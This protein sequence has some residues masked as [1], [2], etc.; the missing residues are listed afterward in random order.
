[1]KFVQLHNHSFFS[2]L[3]GVASPEEIAKKAKEYGMSAVALTDHGTMSGLLRFS[4]ACVKEGIKPILGCEFYLNSNRDN[5]K[6]KEKG[7]NRHIVLLAKS[8]KGY[9]NL[10]KINYDSIVNGFYYKG[11]TDEKFIFSHSR[12]IICMTACLGSYLSY[13]ILKDRIDLAEKK[14]LKYKKVFGDDLYV[15]IMFN[16]LEDQKR[17]NIQLLKMSKRMNVKYIITGDCHYVNEGDEKIQDLMIAI[18]RKKSISDPNVFRFSTRNLFFH[19]PKDYLRFNKEYGYNL[20]KSVIMEG[21]YNTAEVAE[22]CDFHLEHSENPKFPR[23]IDDDKNEVNADFILDKKCRK[24]LLKLNKDTEYKDR[25]ELELKVIKEKNFSDYFLI[26][27]D[28]IRFCEKKG[29][30]HGVGRGSAAGSL[31]SYL[32][33]ITLVDPI[34]FD[35][36]F[37]R[38]LNKSRKDPPDIDIDFESDR[39]KEIEDY[40]K[41]KYGHD[42]VAHIITFTTFR[43]KGALWDVFRAYEKDKDPEFLSIIKKIIDNPGKSSDLFPLS[44]QL[45]N[46][47]D[48]KEIN[49]VKKNKKIFDLAKKLIGR[50]RNVG[51]HAG[52]TAITP[53]PL[54]KHIPVHKVKGDIVTAFIEGKDYRELSDLGVLKVDLLGLDQ[55]DIIKRSIELAK[56]TRNEDVDIYNFNLNDKELFKAIRNYDC[57]GIFQFENTSINDF[58][59]RTKPDCFEDMAT[60]NALYRPAVINA[61]EHEH[62]I[63]RKIKVK[64]WEKENNKKYEGKTE[65]GKLLRNTYGTIAFQEQFMNILHKIGLFTLEEADRA[66]KTFKILYLRRQKTDDKKEDPEL[67]AVV[68]KFREG[69][70]KTT[71]LSDKQIDKWVD[72]LAEFAEYAF[73]RSHSVSYAFIAM[74][75]LYMREYYPLCFYSAI[76]DRTKNGKES[77]FRKTNKMEKYFR[78]ITDSRKLRFA[79]IDINKSKLRFYPDEGKIRIPFSFVPGIGKSLAGEIYK[80]APYRSFSQFCM[81]ELKLRTNKTAILNLIKIGA[82]DSLNKDR[83]ALVLFYEKWSLIRAKYKKKSLKEIKKTMLE[84]WNGE[85]EYND[86]LPIRGQGDFTEEE[87]EEMEKEICKFNVFHRDEDLNSS[88]AEWLHKNH[89]IREITASDS[90]EYCF[91][92]EDKSQERKDR[93]KKPYVY[94]SIVDFKGNRGSCAVFGDVYRVVKN[95]LKKDV[96]YIAYCRKDKRKDV[97]TRELLTLGWGSNSY[98]TCKYNP[99]QKIDVYMKEKGFL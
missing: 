35:L 97:K 84:I 22:K 24:A 33:G 89:G 15:E 96:Y 95:R 40:L 50:I 28:L 2:I 94:L 27:E 36:I 25:M 82:F 55:I 75:T 66:R 1:M 62:Y 91:K 26:I 65:I 63:K 64:N 76:L 90:G 20:S 47:V 19:H 56:K 69:A 3:D 30:D 39:K 34:R 44:D 16:E 49:Y 7:T 45:N 68:N 53:G 46:L 81:K 41:D 48:L 98:R 9:E 59:K 83:K 61:L 11:R 80:G 37:E 72:K 88:R 85:Y 52:G 14:L 43:V 77:N 57:I 10:L 12:D 74:Q 70:K 6:G 86:F 38:F 42:R 51:R 79:P 8:R 18:E 21:I 67:L 13:Y 60:V 23:F 71:N 5:E 99:L 4:N 17:V 54:Y 29:I 93:N 31:V 92:I 78:F 32:L 87:K 73:N 58:L